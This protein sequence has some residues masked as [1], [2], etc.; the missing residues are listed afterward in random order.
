MKIN[1]KNILPTNSANK[2]FHKRSFREESSPTPIWYFNCPA[3]F[4]YLKFNKNKT[5]YFLY[6]WRV[7]LDF[8]SY[9]RILLK[10]NYVKK[11][12]HAH[13]K[14]DKQKLKVIFL[15]EHIRC[16]AHSS[17]GHIFSITRLV[18]FHHRIIETE[19]INKYK[20]KRVC[21]FF[22]WC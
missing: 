4:S 17:V 12:L 22:V 2:A 5:F 1:K 6:N 3:I 13:F 21:A 14:A 16:F 19:A 15:L 10:K 7:V 20:N 8:I 9:Q 11:Q 18:R